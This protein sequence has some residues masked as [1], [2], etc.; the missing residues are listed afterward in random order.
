MDMGGVGGRGD[1]F[2]GK[3]KRIGLEGGAHFQTCQWSD[4]ES[5]AVKV[6]C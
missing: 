6:T 3:H 5:V 1:K 4:S 2:G